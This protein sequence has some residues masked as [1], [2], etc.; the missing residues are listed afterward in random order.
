MAQQ[1]LKKGTNKA[2]KN[3]FFG[4]KQQPESGDAQRP[5]QDGD[6]SPEYQTATQDAEQTISDNILTKS[7]L[8]A[9]LDRLS[10]TLIMS[11]QHSINALRKD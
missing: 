2:E 3:N 4:N 5:P 8:Q 11:W 7:H 9:A 10:Q 6:I 1:K